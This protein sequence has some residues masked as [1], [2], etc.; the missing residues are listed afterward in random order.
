MSEDINQ[1]P[2]EERPRGGA[3]QEF[4]SLWSLAPMWKLSKRPKHCPFG[5]LWQLH[6]IAIINS[7]MDEW[8]LVQS[9]T[10]FPLP[11][12]RGWE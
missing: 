8:Q 6:Y 9:Q 5:F 10:P 3:E 2:E 4:I 1:Q 7:V 11:E 12:I